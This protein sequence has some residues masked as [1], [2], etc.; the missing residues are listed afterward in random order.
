MTG[1]D[2]RPSTYNEIDSYYKHVFPALVTELPHWITPSG[3]HEYAIAFRKP[4]PTRGYGDGDAPDRD[5]I[6]RDTRNSDNTDQIFIPT[7]EKLCT[8]F[9][10]PAAR[11]PLAVGTNRSIGL[12][13]PDSVSNPK[14]VPAATYYALDNWEEFWVLA[15]DIDAKD[16][17]RNRIS[18]E[19]TSFDSISQE[20][21]KQH[22]I[23]QEPP[24]PKKLSGELA[25]GDETD[26]EYVQKYLYTFDDIA[27]SITMAF[28]L[29][30][31]LQNTVG[32]DTVRVFYSGQ[33]THV[34]AFKDDPMYKFTK[35]TREFL[36][37]TYI[38]ERLKIPIDSEV[39]WDQSRVMRLPFS[40]HSDVN[41]VVQEITSEDFD[42][43]NAATIDDIIETHVN[44]SGSISRNSNSNTEPSQQPPQVQDSGHSIE[45]DENE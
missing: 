3:P 11:D 39:T 16:V 13:H 36:A 28:D 31:W 9:Q 10:R 38:T 25:T 23:V 19:S 24:T 21:L 35:Q 18:D 34:Y 27:T 42:F 2:W 15:F 17:A 1:S 6:R 29:R 45:G 30:E 8:F 33:G 5:F 4:H 14:P 20:E 12:I 41:R 22:G 44:D 26:D 37:G 32:F 7:W 43:K 40:L